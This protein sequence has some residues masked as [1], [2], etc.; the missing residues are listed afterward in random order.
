MVADKARKAAQAKARRVARAKA[1]CCVWC[2]SKV[3]A[4][5]SLCNRCLVRK[6]LYERGRKGYRP[7]REGSRGTPPLVPGGDE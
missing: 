3:G 2:P 4:S 7:W 1:G 5:A 6:R